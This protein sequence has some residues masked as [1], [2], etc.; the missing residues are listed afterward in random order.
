MATTTTTT[1]KSAVAMSP[2]KLWFLGLENDRDAD[3]CGRQ[4]QQKKL[5]RILLLDGGVSTH[6]QYNVCCCSSSSNNNNNSNNSGETVASEELDAAAGTTTNISNSNGKNSAFPYRELWSSGLLLSQEG[7]QS[8]LQGHCDWI[9]AGVDVLSTVT[10]QCHYDRSLWPK[11]TRR[12]RAPNAPNTTATIEGTGTATTTA[13][14]AADSDPVLT[15]AIVD[16]MWMDAVHLARGAAGSRTRPK[17]ANSN[18]NPTVEGQRS[19]LVLA[20]SGCYGA[21]L[22]NGAEYTGAYDD[23]LRNSDDDDDAATVVVEEKLRSF[24]ER[25]LRAALAA[26]PDGI[27]FETIPSLV[28]CKALC[29]LLLQSDAALPIACYV[30]L[31]CRND[32]ELNDGTP[33]Q[34]AL[35]VFRDVPVERLQAIGLNCCDAQCLPGLLRIVVPEVLASHRGVVVYPNSGEIWDAASESWL[36]GTGVT[37]AQDMARHLMKYGVHW[38]EQEAIRRGSAIPPIL[39][40][41]CCRTQPATIAALRQLVDRHLLSTE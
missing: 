28:E 5:R 1:T 36:S 15:D 39:I 25:K 32:R 7:Q 30:S 35:E 8:I 33:L 38:I 41:G 26:Q 2:L 3:E 12:R 19:A 9:D 31:A 23:A 17:A 10:Y 29:K 21:A 4:Q 16:Q 13:T 34:D 20:S 11:K 22:A 24:H 18:G 40:G 37:E 14:R 6:L 27:A